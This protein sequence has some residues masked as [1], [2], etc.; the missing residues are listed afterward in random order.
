MREAGRIAAVALVKMGEMIRPGVSTAELDR[1]AEEWIVSR[2]ATCEFMGYHGY[3]ANVC[4][5]V[6]A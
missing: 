4:A 6:C 2:G 3:P 5:S 1:K